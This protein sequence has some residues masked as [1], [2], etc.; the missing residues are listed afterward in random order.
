MPPCRNSHTPAPQQY[1]RPSLYYAPQS[2]QTACKTFVL[3]A[4]SHLRRDSITRSPGPATAL[5]GCPPDPRSTQTVRRRSPRVS[6]RCARPR[7]PTAP[8]TRPGVHAEIEHR[9]LRS[10]AKVAGVQRKVRKNRHPRRLRSFE[11]QRSTALR[12]DAQVRRIPCGQPL[13]VAGLKNTPPTPTA[14]AISTP[15]AG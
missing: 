15:P 7:R 13:R 11:C 6:G 14:L 8:A 4:K 10:I 3:H 1:A 9:L 2:P 5:P 12:G